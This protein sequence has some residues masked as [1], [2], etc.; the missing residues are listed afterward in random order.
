MCQLRW[1]RWMWTLALLCSAEPH[2][3]V[4]VSHFKLHTSHSGLTV[5]NCVWGRA[6]FLRETSTADRG[7]L[8]RKLTAVQVQSSVGS[9]NSVVQMNCRW[10][11][12]LSDLAPLRLFA[13]LVIHRVERSQLHF[14]NLCIQSVRD[15]SRSHPVNLLAFITNKEERSLRVWGTAVWNHYLK[16]L[17][18]LSAVTICEDFPG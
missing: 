13:N 12:G 2:V 7:V 6:H 8:A 16:A 4:A 17:H 1:K 3:A 15:E 5:N 11:C 10:R 14:Y 9:W 18:W